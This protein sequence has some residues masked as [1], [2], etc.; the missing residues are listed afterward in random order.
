LK[1]FALNQVFDAH[2]LAIYDEP[3]AAIGLKIFNKRKQFLDS[4]IPIFQKHHQT[5]TDSAEEVQLK[6]ESQLFENSLENLLKNNLP[7]TKPYN[8]LLLE[9][10]KMIYRLKLI[11]FQLRNLVHKVNKNRF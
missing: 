5:I 9:Y 2:N 8:I 1:Y 4:F 6:Y 10:T 3:M 7:K 11:V